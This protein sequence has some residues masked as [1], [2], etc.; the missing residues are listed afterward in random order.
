MTPTPAPTYRVEYFGRLQVLQPI[1]PKE[2]S[3]K[4]LS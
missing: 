1:R 2:Q 3:C 4:P